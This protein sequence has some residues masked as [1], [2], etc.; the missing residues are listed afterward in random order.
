MPFHPGDRVRLIKSTAVD[1]APGPAVGTA[2]TVIA[3]ASRGVTGGI[4][5]VQFDNFTEQ[6]HAKHPPGVWFV[7]SDEIELV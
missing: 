1:D 2:G 6:F 7:A 4:W 5:R 3:L